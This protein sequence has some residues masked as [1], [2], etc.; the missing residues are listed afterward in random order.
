MNKLHALNLGY[1]GAIIA[2]FIM[3]LLGIL[4][5]LGVYT[6]GVE[7]MMQWHLLFSLSFMGII[8]GMI[9][10]ALTTFVL[11]YAF[12]LTYNWLLKSRGERE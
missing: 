3:L 7:A 4:G 10:G 11:L 2:A 12:A 8:G 5:N 6:E 9:E 1:S